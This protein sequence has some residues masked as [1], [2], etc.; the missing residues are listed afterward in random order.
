MPRIL[1]VDDEADIRSL[2]ADILSDDGH[3]CLQAGDDATALALFADCSPDLV[4]LDIWLQ[5]S[6]RDGISILSELRRADPHVPVLMISGH[7]SIEIAVSAIQSG[8][9]DFIE[10]P[11]KIDQLRVVVARALEASQLR[12]E[13][14]ERRERERTTGALIG[15][16]AAVTQLRAQIAR[17]APTNSRVLLTGPAGAGKEV[18]ARQLHLQSRR[19]EG[20]F[21]VVNSAAIEAHR[22]EE[23][24]LGS[25]ATA[26]HPARPG[27][28]DQANG[29]TLFFDEIADLPLG[30]Q[31][32]LLRILIDQKFHRPGDDMVVRV[33]VRVISATSRDLAAE[34]AAG[35]FREDLFHR[36]NVVPINLPP[37]HQRREDI[38]AL[39][40]HFIGRL[41]REQGL[42]AR[43]ISPG[44]LAVMQAYDWPGNVR[45]LK[46][47][48]ERM[49]I[50]GNSDGVLTVDDLPAELRGT[51]ANR[52]AV[53]DPRLL[54]LPLREAREAFERDYIA[55]QIQRFGGN[56]SRTADFIGMERSALHRKMKALGL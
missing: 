44:A 51:D 25:G 33:D 32:K 9:Y 24:L 42:P 2:L 43:Q 28:L 11:F 18:V 30:A 35:R 34:I 13:A 40:Q 22:F 1:I 48:V 16:S 29:G 53:V 39:V 15:E 49:L 41:N 8:A 7:G 56:I 37:L 26:N 23:V 21:V 17:T 47:I 54:A 12:R 3:D 31:S 19:A 6:Q 4:I 14:R 55:A 46:N 36:L 20:R 38:P 50:L 45:Q 52:Q 27:L 5:G 10:K